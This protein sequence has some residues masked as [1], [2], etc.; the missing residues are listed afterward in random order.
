MNQVD[1]GRVCV[2]RAPRVIN[3]RNIAK[4]ESRAVEN[5][6]P[7]SSGYMSPL[8]VSPI[9]LF[10]AVSQTILRSSICGWYP[11]FF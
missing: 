7:E 10:D 4:K 11:R 6:L 9:F 3:E 1:S 2:Y 8:I 5:T